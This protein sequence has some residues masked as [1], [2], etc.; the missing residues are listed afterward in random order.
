MLWTLGD[1]QDLLKKHSI[2]GNGIL[3]KK[4][5]F[6]GRSGISVSLIATEELK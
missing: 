5:S 1:S 2:F 4:T 6:V 3:S